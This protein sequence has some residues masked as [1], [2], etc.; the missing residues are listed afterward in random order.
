MKSRYKII[1]IGEI[2][3][4]VL[5]NGKQ[6]G[7]AP[8]NFAY[9]TSLLGN[10]GI[11][12]SRVGID[13]LGQETLSMMASL[14]LSTEFV[15]DD[16]SHSTGTAVVHVD[17]GGQPKFTIT[18]NVAWDFLEWTD[19]WS[20]LAQSA[21]VVC[22]GSLGQRNPI[23]RETI[24]KFLRVAP[25]DALRV[26]DVNLRQNFF[27]AELLRDSLSLAQIVKLNH[28][29]IPVVTQMLGVPFVDYEHAS[30]Q[31]LKTFGLKLVCVTCGGE[32]SLL[33]TPSSTS[34]HKGFPIKVADTVGAGDAFT[35]CM[36]HHFLRGTKLHQINES[37]NRFAAWVA[38][39]PGATP[40]RDEMVLKE[41]LTA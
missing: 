30:R 1:G 14:G 15:Q 17:V 39:Q 41:V 18:P 35:A 28:E 5:P 37:A 34:R 38:S 33:V 7:G 29:E 21:D 9:M 16:N 8:A 26:F 36:V 32:G 22:F 31:L 4:D 2:L 20:R 24:G 11:V 12:A 27:S 10:E 23:S 13:R 19:S 25:D 40:P 6:L 3:W